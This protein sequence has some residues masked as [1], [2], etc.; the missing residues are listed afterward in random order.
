MTFFSLKGDE[1]ICLPHKEKA[2]PLGW[3][4]PTRLYRWD[5]ATN[6]AFRKAA[7][8]DGVPEDDEDIVT[9][10][11]QLFAQNDLKR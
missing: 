6:L 3:S 4:N 9:K 11:R 8:I 7:I 5:D 2:N 1:L 10:G